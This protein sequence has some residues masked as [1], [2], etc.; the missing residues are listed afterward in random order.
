MSLLLLASFMHRRCISWLH[1]LCTNL[2]LAHS[3]KWCGI[4]HWASHHL[5]K[6]YSFR[7]VRR[8]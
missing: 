6:W 3:G 5:S 2:N 4:L 1:Q 7:R 8:I